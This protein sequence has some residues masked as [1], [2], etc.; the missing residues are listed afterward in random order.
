[1]YKPRFTITNT[2]AQNLM[3]IQKASILVENLPLPS[4]I[5][6]TL[7]KE[8]REET[9]ILSTKLEG[10][11]LDEQAKR[12]A[13]Y[14]QNTSGEQQEVY[15]LMKAIDYLDECEE[16]Q[17]PITEEFIKKLQQS[18]ELLTTVVGLD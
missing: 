15:N 12:E 17:L 14:L 13:L 10:N 6:D 7:K 3:E 8:S 4:S 1:M 18:S 11:T 16:R 2:I 9:V 5:L